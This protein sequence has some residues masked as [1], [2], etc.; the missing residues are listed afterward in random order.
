MN[1]RCSVL[2]MLV[3]L[4]TT[5]AVYGQQRPLVTEDP[6]TIGNGRV[7]LEGGVE[8]ANGV[9]NKAYGIE[10][11]ITRIGTFGVSVGAGAIAE[12]QVDGGVVQQ[13]DVNR[14]IPAGS[15]SGFVLALPGDTTSDS[16]IC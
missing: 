16:K 1:M 4:V 12:V 9:T 6:E 2:T 15:L 3:W 8:F 5:G 11:D 7:L 13:F 14:R 10:G